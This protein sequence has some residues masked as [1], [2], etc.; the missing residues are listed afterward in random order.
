MSESKTRP[1][2]YDDQVQLSLS[3]EF[4]LDLSR[5][6]RDVY[7]LL[8]WLGDVGGLRDALFIIGAFVMLVRFSI[9]G[10]ILEAWIL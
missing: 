3:Y 9:S 7:N 10:D 8:D 5:V 2:E 6:D 4:N 1:Y